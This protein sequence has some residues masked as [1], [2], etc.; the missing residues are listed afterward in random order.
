MNSRAALP[1][2]LGEITVV[3]NEILVVETGSIRS[4][5]EKSRSTYKI[6]KALGSKGK[7]ISVEW[8]DDNIKIAKDICKEF[9]NIEYVHSDSVKYL[10]E[11]EHAFHLAYLD[12][13]NNAAHIWNE[14]RHVV[15]KMVTGGIVVIDDYQRGVKCDDVIKFLKE[16]EVPFKIFEQQILI[17]V[18]DKLKGIL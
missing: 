12:S 2:A 13:A 8:N 17:D 1:I 9:K 18:T 3:Y 14:F 6:A 15:P 4:Y 10:R 16:K 5:H 7:L 11:T